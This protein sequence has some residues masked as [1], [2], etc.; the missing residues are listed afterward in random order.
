[1]HRTVAEIQRI[2]WEPPSF[3]PVRSQVYS[4]IQQFLVYE[5]LLLDHGLYDLW[6]TILF[7]GIIYSVC[8]CTD[9]TKM[10]LNPAEYVVRSRES[11]LQ[12]L[13]GADTPIS[14]QS[15]ADR[16][17]ATR[18]FVTN[19]SVSFTQHRQEY[20]VLSYVRVASIGRNR[21]STAAW[22][23]ERRD[24]LSA[25]DQSFV[26]CRRSLLIDWIEPGDSGPPLFL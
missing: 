3:I 2:R 25:T 18:R 5:A 8:A 4:D 7:P 23:A 16:L 19:I 26:I 1:M 6:S 22:S 10:G 24:H 20:D 17:P 12:R 13:G 9:E 11:M 21:S 14:E 15:S